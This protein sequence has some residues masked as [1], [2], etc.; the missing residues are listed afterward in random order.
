MKIAFLQEKT[1]KW[2]TQL[3]FVHLKT[4]STANVAFLFSENLM[5]IKRKIFLYDFGITI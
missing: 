2:S 5:D 3:F 1:K 4:P